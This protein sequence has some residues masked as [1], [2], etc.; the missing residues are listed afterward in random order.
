MESRPVVRPRIYTLNAL[1]ILLPSS[2]CSCGFERR[3]D[4]YLLLT[5]FTHGLC[6]D[7]PSDERAG[8]TGGVRTFV[9]LNGLAQAHRRAVWCPR[10]SAS[11]C[12]GSRLTCTCRSGLRWTR[13]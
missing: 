11:S 3:K 2:P 4:G 8:H 13:R 6:A 12:W 1:L 9:A 10:G 5:A 7:Q